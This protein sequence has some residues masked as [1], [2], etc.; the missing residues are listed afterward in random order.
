[1]EITN[2]SK[3]SSQDWW[4][5]L[6]LPFAT[7]GGSVIGTFIMW[8]MLRVGM[9]SHYE[10]SL[11]SWW[12]RYVMTA[13]LS[14]VFGCLYAYIACE[15]A[16]RGKVIAGTVMVTIQGG[17]TVIGLLNTWAA[18]DIAIGSQIQ[19]TVGSVATMVAAVLTLVDVNG[20]KV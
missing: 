2:T 12:W 20:K 18:P 7:F 9:M 14:A 6:L 1:M 4:R 19:M 13:L 17:I 10:I 3:A 11:D 8:L 5:W 16:P 15:V